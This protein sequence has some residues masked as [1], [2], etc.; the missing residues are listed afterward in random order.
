MMKSKRNSQGKKKEKEMRGRAED[1]FFSFSKP[2]LL[3]LAA[4]VAALNFGCQPNQTILKDA[5][6]GPTPMATVESKKTTFDEDLREMQTADF[7]YILVFR[8]K[9][10]GE[11]DK[12]DQ[13]FLRDNTPPETNRWRKS[14]DGKSFIAGSGF[15]FTPEQMTALQN[16]FIVEDYSKPEI[17]EAA[18][19]PANTNSNTANSNSAGKA[20]ANK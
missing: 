18:D 3:F 16:R 2:L 17:K 6:P 14:D 7:D 1:G 20:Q 15:G 19:K 5:A 10:G 8:R 11:F 9:D 4:G 13:K 12:D